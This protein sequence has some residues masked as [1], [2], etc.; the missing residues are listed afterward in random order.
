MSLLIPHTIILANL[1]FIVSLVQVDIICHFILQDS[2]IWTLLS[3]HQV[4]LYIVVSQFF[5]FTFD[6][7]NS[8]FHIMHQKISWSLFLWTKQIALVLF[9]RLDDMKH[10]LDE[11]IEL[12]SSLRKKESLYRDA[13]SRRCQDLRKAETEVNFKL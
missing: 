3:Q 7:G 2:R 11:L 12:V 9:D 1:S 8:T 4:V 13:F 10:H 5:W 6:A